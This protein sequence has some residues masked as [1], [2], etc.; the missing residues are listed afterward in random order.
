[1]PL[2]LAMSDPADAWYQG[3]TNAKDI[4]EERAVERAF[5]EWADGDSIASHVAHGI[6]V[7]CTEDIG[8]SNASPSVLDAANRAWLEATY[9]VNF[10][11]FDELI[12][13][14]P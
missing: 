3:L 9:G 6:D 4:H 1:M 5:S 8:R 10:M 12:A 11:S 7:F 14:I 2:G 13:T